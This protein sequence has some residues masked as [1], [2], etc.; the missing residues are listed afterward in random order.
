MGRITLSLKFT[1]VDESTEVEEVRD[2]LQQLVEGEF[3][4]WELELELVG[5]DGVECAECT[6]DRRMRKQ[7]KLD[8]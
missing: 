3:P 7:H 2:F 8:E 1:C 6:E 4:E 5:H